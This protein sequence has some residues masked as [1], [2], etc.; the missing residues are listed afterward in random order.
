MYTLY[1]DVG[2]A[3]MA[4]H[5]IL[6]EVGA[7][8]RL[9]RVDTDKGEH[10]QPAYLK[11]N[12]HGRVP[13][14]ADDGMVMYESAAICLHLADRHPQAGLAPPVESPARAHYLQWMTF[15]TN[16]VQET[17]IHWFHPDRYGP[18]EVATA[19][20]DAAVRRLD[21][22]WSF[23]DGQLAGEGPFLLGETASAA[24]IYLAMLARWSRNMERPAGAHPH[25]RAL[26]ERVRAR[27]AYRRML[28]L[29][30]ITQPLPGEAVA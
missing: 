23:L 1:W 2:T 16:T 21:R 13:A 18:A 25:L 27:P 30:G 4:P 15:L 5:A 28:E 3:A 7:P 24:D 14:L 17:L 20:Q 6:E 8:Y 22:H 29:Q 10:L 12:P 26:I 9:V 11:I 19:I